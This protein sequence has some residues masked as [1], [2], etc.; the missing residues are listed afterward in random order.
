[1]K[2][3]RV[4]I[5]GAGRQG[6]ATGEFLNRRGYDV[7]MVDI[8]TDNLHRAKKSGLK[9]EKIDLSMKDNLKR[10][11]KDFDTA[12]CAL[13]SF[14]GRAAWKAAIEMKTNLIDM[15]YQKKV[16]MDLDDLAAEEGII[17]IPDA[18]IAP[19]VSNFI[20]GNIKSKVDKLNLLKVLVGGIPEKNISPLGYKVTWSPG[21]LIEEYMRP[22]RIKRNGELIEVPPLSDI[23]EIR[24][25]GIDD[26][27]AFYTDGLRTLLYTMN[28]VDNLEEKTIRYRGHAEKIKFLEEMGYF[29]EKCDDYSPREVSTC[30]ISKLKFKDTRDILLLRIIS[31]GVKNKKVKNCTFEIFDRGTDKHTAM[32]RTTGFG[33]GMFT[34]L[35][36]Q[37]R[38]KHRGVIPPEIFGADDDIFKKGI[39][40][41]KEENII[42]KSL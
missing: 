20:S 22:A 28:D 41:L 1:M 27:E 26:L 19:G 18:G 5:L 15:S 37:N 16:P 17:I 40:L 39:N 38:I 9:T 13:P 33:C 30:L 8:S 12:V 25:K 10:C 42:V 3:K 36:L 31:R 23:E 6:R 29:K 32:E 14:M 4:I 11:M 21:D 7:S 24:W 34:A 2:T 35:V